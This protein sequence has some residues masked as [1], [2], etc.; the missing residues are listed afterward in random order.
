[1]LQFRTLVSLI[2]AACAFKLAQ[3]IAELDHLLCQ[4]LL[5]FPEYG[6]PVIQLPK[7]DFSLGSLWIFWILRR[8][9]CANN[10]RNLKSYIQSFFPY[11]FLHFAFISFSGLS[12]VL[13][14]AKHK[15]C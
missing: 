8:S 11:R 2:F 9:D 1:Y 4:K 6:R 15:R 3:T 12:V 14:Q 10:I 7:S 13:N 5:V